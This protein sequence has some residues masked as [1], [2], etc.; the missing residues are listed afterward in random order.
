[1]CIIALKMALE[2]NPQ[3]ISLVHHSDRGV[4]YCC[5]DYVALLEKHQV[6]ISM[7]QSGDPLENALAER[8][9]GIL[10]DELLEEV[11]AD[12][13]QARRGV[14]VAMSTYNYQRPHGSIDMLTPVMA[15]LRTGELKRNWKNYYKKERKEVSMT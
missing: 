5:A 2:N 12:L 9:N 4:Q 15:H 14:A 6:A 10:K 3:I 11:Y 7:T 1:G 8:V 13:D